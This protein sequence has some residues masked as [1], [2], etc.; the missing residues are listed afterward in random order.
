MK[1]TGLR[2]N[3]MRALTIVQ[4]ILTKNP[5]LPILENV[6][7]ETDN[8]QLKISTTNLEMGVRLWVKGK[9]EEDGKVCIPATL[10]SSIVSHIREE[11]ITLESQGLNAL[12]STQNFQGTIKG[13]DANEFP[14]IP[15]PQIP[16][17]LPFNVKHLA[18]GLY[19]V[20]YIATIS[21]I[22]PEISGVLFLLSQDGLTLVATDSFRLGKKEVAMSLPKELVGASF[23]LPLKPAQELAFILDQSVQ[24]TAKVGWSENQVLFL[25][26]DV[27]V[28][29]RLL[30]GS[31]PQV[32]ELIPKDF[33]LD[34]VA[35]KQELID[36]IKL[37]S[38]F[39]PKT[40]DCKWE[41]SGSQLKISSSATLGSS[42]TT[43]KVKAKGSA[44][45]Q[46]VFN[47]RYLLDGLLHID[48]KEV[49]IRLNNEAT[50]VVFYGQGNES[51]LYLVAPLK[52][53]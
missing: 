23:I 52:S 37:I 15:N 30:A 9:V 24:P 51:Y 47:Y 40:N 27:Q 46:I 44:I 1:F 8:K 4:R 32:N 34:I 14:L 43:L 28:V 16:T 12:I 21:E 31:Y 35:D 17:M 49:L 29:F 6:L 22:Y 2:E 18:Q 7:I 42:Q 38:A 3:L 48:Q 45:A 36:A 33:S 11:R 41:L 50:P 5:S 26:E 39:A 25:L 10:L 53:S 13:Q 20:H 19:Q